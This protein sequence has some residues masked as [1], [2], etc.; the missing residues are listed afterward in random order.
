MYK[1]S[2]RD[3]LDYRARPNVVGAVHA[4]RTFY[5]CRKAFCTSKALLDK[6]SAAIADSCQFIIKLQSETV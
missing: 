1:V 5:G 2:N 3:S 6:S 4:V